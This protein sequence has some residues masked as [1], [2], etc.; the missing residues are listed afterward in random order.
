MTLGK[1]F[2]GKFYY[3][4]D[5]GFDRFRQE[6]NKKYR[7]TYAGIHAYVVYNYLDLSSLQ[8]IRSGLNDWIFYPLSL[9][10]H[11]YKEA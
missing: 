7:N 11:L 9:P 5:M 6:K 10:M 4:A 1:Y 8:P 2:L 3:L